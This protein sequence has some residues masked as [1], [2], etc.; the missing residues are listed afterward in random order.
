[1]NRKIREGLIKE[2]SKEQQE[3]AAALFIQKRLKGILARKQIELL[4]QEEMYFLGM[5]RRPKT[6]QE[7]TRDPLQRMK[8]IQEERR[9]TRLKFMDDFKTAREVKKD[10]ILADEG[11]DL[12]EQMKKERRDWI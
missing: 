9:A 7:R 1:M 6:V 5:S 11:D 8:T 2:Q 3:N 12:M 10:E 4:R